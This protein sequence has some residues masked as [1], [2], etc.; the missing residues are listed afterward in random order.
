[1]VQIWI[2]KSNFSII[3]TQEKH[4]VT[5][6][7]VFHVP[8]FAILNSIEVGIPKKEE[9]FAGSTACVTADLQ[10]YELHRNT[11]STSATNKTDSSKDRHEANQ[12][13]RQRSK[14]PRV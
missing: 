13:T 9:A 2:G 6:I 7:Q 1:M 5:G 11:H 3:G 10:L 4:L 12:K 14:H 8:K